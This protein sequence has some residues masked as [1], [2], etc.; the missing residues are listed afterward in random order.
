MKLQTPIFR[1]VKEFSVRWKKKEHEN[2]KGTNAT[3]TE[4]KKK[5]RSRKRIG[6]KKQ[7]AC[8]SLRK[9]RTDQAKEGELFSRYQLI[10]R[11]TLTRMHAM[12]YFVV[13]VRDRDTTHKKAQVI[14]SRQKGL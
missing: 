14:Y 6:D 9:Y 4:T 13:D 7:K 2:E 11:I 1:K 8:K 12:C 5:E 3:E 10:G